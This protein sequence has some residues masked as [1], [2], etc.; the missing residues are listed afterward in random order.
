MSALT[1]HIEIG[2][3]ASLRSKITPEGFTHDWE[4]Y[5]RGA[6]NADIHHYVEKVVFYL[7]ETFPKP[8]RGRERDLLNV[9]QNFICCFFSGK[10]APIFGENVRLCWLQLAH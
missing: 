4:V 1:V 2:H 10:R 5:V 8:K 9:E 7:H 3:E 6:N